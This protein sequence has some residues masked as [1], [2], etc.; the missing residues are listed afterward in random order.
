MQRIGNFKAQMHNCM[1][2]G[3][4]TGRTH[5]RVVFVSSRARYKGEMQ[6]IRKDLGALYLE[7]F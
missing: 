6:R 1:N 5:S 3:A 4:V 2:K 7:V